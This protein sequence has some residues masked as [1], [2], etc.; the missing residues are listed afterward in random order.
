M[1]T[2]V[3]SSGDVKREWHVIDAENQALGRL[4]SRVANVLRGKHRPQY[5]P[6][7][8]AGDFVVIINAEKVRLTGRKEDQK[9]YIRH[10]GFPGGVKSTPVKVMR[11]THPERIIEN[12]VRGMLPKNPLGRQVF[13][14]LKVYAGERHPHQAQQPKP[15]NLD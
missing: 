14:K 9:V 10:T 8:D 3:A 5:T 11:A 15:L 2:W 1:R 4:A 7:A 12:A 6:H 13:K